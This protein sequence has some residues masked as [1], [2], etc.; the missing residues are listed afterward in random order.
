MGVHQNHYP[1][2][3]NYDTSAVQ[4]VL[5]WY[6]ARAGLLVR[7]LLQGLTVR[8]LWK[9]AWSPLHC[10]PSPGR[11]CG[12]RLVLHSPSPTGTR[13]AGL[14]PR[15]EVLSMFCLFWI[16]TVPFSQ[17]NRLPGRSGANRLRIHGGQREVMYLWAT[18]AAVFGRD[19]VSESLPK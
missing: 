17:P 11:Q 19:C 18:M 9:G 15:E 7:C 14:V 2:P 3:Q 13:S 10:V 12:C 8:G 6:G 5:H 16:G 4:A 1:H